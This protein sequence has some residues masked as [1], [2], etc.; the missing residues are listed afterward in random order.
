MWWLQLGAVELLDAAMIQA[1]NAQSGFSYAN[2]PHLFFKFSG[3]AAKVRDDA[4]IVERLSG[5]HGGS[6]FDWSHDTAAAGRLWEAR[7][8]ALWSAAAMDTSKK[9]I[10]TDVCVPISRMP[11]LMAAMEA[12]AARSSLKVYAVAHVGDGNAHHFIA[13]NPD[14]AHEAAEAHR[15]CSFLVTTA[16]SMDGTCTG[17]HGVGAGKTE[18][19]VNEIGHGGVAFMKF[20][21]AAVDPAHIMN[22]GK[23]LPLHLPAPPAP[24]THA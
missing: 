18:Y 5:M 21:K 20:L 7:K 16:Q 12:E 11:D 19:L 15:L 13:F 4:A 9:I 1:V 14:D 22:P 6:A 8:V 17:E 2:T 24:S 23:K 3:S 10:T